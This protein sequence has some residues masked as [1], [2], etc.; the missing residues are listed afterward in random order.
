MAYESSQARG[1]IGAR[2]AGNATA[3]AMPERATSA[4]YTTAHACRIFNQPTEQGQGS[5]LHPQGS[6]LRS[7]PAE[8]QRELPSPL[9]LEDPTKF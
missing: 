3:T 5:N 1:Q 2:A 4:T 8:P 7:K 9:L 6:Y